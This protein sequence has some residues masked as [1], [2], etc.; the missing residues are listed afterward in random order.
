MAESGESGPGQLPGAADAGNR[1]ARASGRGR[2]HQPARRPPDRVRHAGPQSP[3]RGPALPPGCR[4]R[5]LPLPSR[6]RRGARR[7]NRRGSAGRDG[8]RPGRGEPRPDPGSHRRDPMGGGTLLRGDRQL[9]LARGSP[10]RAGPGGPAEDRGRGLRRRPRRFL[11]ASRRPGPHRAGLGGRGAGLPLRRLAD[12]T[13][14]RHRAGGRL[15]L[16]RSRAAGVRRRRTAAPG[17]RR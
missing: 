1:G 11:P 3:G 13:Q 6:G 2:F 4:L 8:P 16:A 5:P 14:E 12:R 17:A 15:R 7:P 10:H 9:A